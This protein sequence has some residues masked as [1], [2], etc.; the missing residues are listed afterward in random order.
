MF[1]RL[2]VACALA[3]LTAG[4][5]QA[6]APAPAAHT[7]T[8]LNFPPTLGPAQFVRSF[9]YPIGR[10]TAYSYAYV[11][12]AMHITVQVYEGS[13]RV[14]A[15]S[16]NPTVVNQFAEELSGTDRTLRTSG[17]ANV[18]RPTVPSVCTAGSV[19]FR[20]ILY[21]VSGQAGQQFSKML[22]TGYNDHFLKIR[23][24]W[25]QSTG[26]SAADADKILQ[27]F[28]AALLR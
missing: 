22:L 11:A 19:R 7:G 16:D 21:T 3:V 26:L 18:D 6:Q 10:T 8:R 24:E 20:C 28:V 17:Y 4:L 1:R 2:A 12:N 13:R 15:G 25:P 14:P 9:T 5:A 23:I 27:P